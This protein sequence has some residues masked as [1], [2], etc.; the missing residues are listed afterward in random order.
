M[1][2]H[3]D[4]KVLSIDFDYFQKVSIE[5][6]N[7]QNITCFLSFSGNLSAIIKTVNKLGK[8]IISNIVIN[9]IADTS[10]VNIISYCTNDKILSIS[11]VCIIIIKIPT[12]TW[13]LEKV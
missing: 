8:Y 11:K 10:I 4:K 2:E 3:Y 9:E 6:I 5:T 12:C 1:S 7:P 13:G